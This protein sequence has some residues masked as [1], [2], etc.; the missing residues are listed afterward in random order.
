M[1]TQAH[2]DL[3]QSLYIAYYGRA[4]DSGGLEF[5]ANKIQEDG[6]ESVLNDFGNSA[7]FQDRFGS[8]NN[9]ELVDNLYQQ[10]FDRSAELEGLEFWTGKLESGELNLA[11]IAHAIL[12]GAQEPDSSVLA[13]KLAAANAYTASAGEDYVLEEGIA[14]VEDATQT[15]PD[16]TLTQG[17]DDLTG[18]PGDDTF[19][20][21]LAQ[22]ELGGV[23]NTLASGDSIDGGEGTDELRADV[24]SENTQV[25]GT[26]TVIEPE[27]T[28][29]ENFFFQAQS[30]ATPLVG[31][32]GI[33]E[34]IEDLSELDDITDLFDLSLS[35]GST[36]P[37]VIDA[38]SMQG[39]EQLWSS[40][41]RADLQ[42]EDV[43]SNPNA[44]TIGME[45]TDHNVS[46]FV[47]YDADVIAGDFGDSAVTYEFS[48]L[49]APADELD[50]GTAAEGWVDELSF[51]IDGEL[52]TLNGN[53]VAAATTYQELE[54][55][56]RASLD[57]QGY[58][59]ISVSLDE[60]FTAP[61]TVGGGAG[62]QM[63]LVDPEG[64]TLSEPQI[65]VA[66]A[67]PA[68]AL[69]FNSDTGAPTEQDVETNVI[70]DNV[71]RNDV[72]GILDIGGMSN[73]GV[74]VFNVEV[75]EKSWL[76]QMQS[77]SVSV[78]PDTDS[79]HHLEVVNVTHLAG[80]AEGDLAIGSQES[81]ANTDG[82]WTSMPTGGRVMTNG[83]QDVRVFNAD[84]F[85]GAIN[86]GASFTNEIFGRYLDDAEEPVNFN[87]DG[88]DGGNLFTF[89]FEGE[90]VGTDPDFK[91]NVTGGSEDDRFNFGGVF[92]WNN[93]SVDGEE[94]F[95]TL[96][97][98]SSIGTTGNEP[99]GFNSIEKLVLA[100]DSNVDAGMAELP[101]VQEVWVATNGTDSMIT[102]LGADTTVTLSGKKQTLGNA[103]G[104]NDQD[105]G[106]VTLTDAQAED[107]LVTLDNTARLDGVLTVESITVDGPDSNVDTLTLNSAGRRDTR[108]VVQDISAAA[109][110]SI[111]L[112]GSQDLAAKV[113][114]LATGTDQELTVDGSELEGDLDLVVNGALLEEGSDDVITG[115]AGENDTLALYGTGLDVSP[116]I[117]DFETLQ[118]GYNSFGALS[119]TLG[120]GSEAFDGTFDVGNADA[121]TFIIAHESGDITL[122][123]LSSGD[124]VVIG[125]EG[126]GTDTLEFDNN[127]FLQ[128]SGDDI[129]INI[130]DTVDYGSST[131]FDNSGFNDGLFVNGFATINLDLAMTGGEDV[132]LNLMID[133]DVD[134]T[135]FPN[136]QLL[137]VA[138]R[139]ASELVITGG[140]ADGS[141]DLD[142]SDRWLPGTLDEIDVSG[143]NSDTGG[144]PSSSGFDAVRIVMEDTGSSSTSVAADMTDTDFTIGAGNVD[145]TLNADAVADI[146]HNATFAFTGDTGTDTS[147]SVWTIT[148]FIDEAN[149]D[150]GNS[151][152]SQLDLRDLGVEGITDLNFAEDQYFTDDVV[153]T[154][155]TGDWEIV[156]V[157]QDEAN[158]APSENFLFAA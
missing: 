13:S 95:N 11:E 59:D 53:D 14:A 10:M 134:D 67:A 16:L 99:A 87:Y 26:S 27:T 123:G 100:G 114:S 35:L 98:E 129:N 104:D 120:G 154:D 38:G 133:R 70:L 77:T 3:A 7:E 92:D 12:E 51:Q 71:G 93:V 39:V 146:E 138:E 132:D 54:A 85:S 102:D 36:A 25:G 2:F 81:P 94:G 101:G 96:E 113:T 18:T 44:T 62:A 69:Y 64:R 33:G 5:W 42:I 24:I 60:S 91:L 150:S 30:E 78:D 84:G 45:G 29:V 157:G 155:N 57:A 135:T 103:N 43:R 105:I 111:L 73:K 141:N 37:V 52:V 156:L 122:E 145:I 28:S 1:A 82:D 136:Y 97:T 117:E 8:L 23:T 61:A 107:Q 88:G 86:L 31:E 46:Y 65:N 34:F 89:D 47:K 152:Y 119:T 22:N 148:N 76:A 144:D 108:N 55:A 20:A 153:I 58:E 32:L 63:V 143:F 149:G 109:A 130:L 139:D 79:F 49:L 80:G 131:L 90:T 110:S 83:L 147:P 66:D 115:T 40:E 75:D 142:L 158:L 125:E 137:P 118:L 151:N 112:T 127:I 128:G 15:A 9:D 17:T 116:T 74:Q 48:N 126:V 19:T 41:S 50:I 121:D 140:V 106:E 124:T 6:P 72:G 56:V 4:A 68:G 21:P